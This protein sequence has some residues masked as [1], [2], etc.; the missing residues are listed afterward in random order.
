MT[1]ILGTC[2]LEQTGTNLS[3]IVGLNGIP[4]KTARNAPVVGSRQQQQQQRQIARQ[5]LLQKA[6]RYIQGAVTTT[7]DGIDD[8]NLNKKRGMKEEQ[9]DEVVEITF[10][11][12]M[13]QKK[14]LL[15]NNQLALP[16]MTNE[17]DEESDPLVEAQKSTDFQLPALPANLPAIRPSEAN[18]IINVL[19]KI[20]NKNTLLGERVQNV[21][22]NHIQNEKDKKSKIILD[23]YQRQWKYFHPQKLLRVPEI[24][25]KLVLGRPGMKGNPLDRLRKHIFRRTIT[26]IHIQEMIVEDPVDAVNEE[27]PLWEKVRTV[28]QG[29]P[30]SQEGDIL[31]S[32]DEYSDQS[33]NPERGAR[34][35]TRNTRIIQKAKQISDSIVTMSKRRRK[36]EEGTKVRENVKKQR[37]S[38][39]ALDPIITQGYEEAC[40]VV[41]P[42]RASHTLP[43]SGDEFIEDTAAIVDCH[44]F[45]RSVD[46]NFAG[47]VDLNIFKNLLVEWGIQNKT[48]NMIKVLSGKKSNFSLSDLFK[49]MY[50]DFQ[51]AEEVQMMIRAIMKHE[52]FRKQNIVSTPPVLPPEDLQAIK[53]SFQ[54]LVAEIELEFGSIESCTVQKLLQ[55]GALTAEQVTT[56]EMLSGDRNGYMGLS[57]YVMMMCT[58]GHRPFKESTKALVGD[59]TLAC[60]VEGL[61]GWYDSKVISRLDPKRG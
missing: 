12:K 47:R 7:E 41:Y 54:F 34:N 5:K 14:M 18:F 31:D 38:K 16:A 17:N 3:A 30:P 24:H 20:P 60:Y 48:M 32:N 27:K 28:I 21:F 29:R 56:Y 23:T 51:Y 33:K 26:S 42:D 25:Q 57:E 59:G 52:G 6:E 46:P 44:K 4:P 2:E 50:P 13:I 35:K 36:K 1:I 22:E 10:Y 53:E 15:F 55:V 40:T 11:D 19:N 49:C 58:V 61:D 37:T 45:W 9:E 39:F 8:E 43:K